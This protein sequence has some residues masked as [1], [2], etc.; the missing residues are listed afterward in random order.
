VAFH[1]A[2]DGGL[3][4]KGVCWSQDFGF[5]DLPVDFSRFCVCVA[6]AAESSLD[7][8]AWKGLWIESVR[9]PSQQAGAKKNGANR[10]PEKTRHSR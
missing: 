4:Q 10:N 7:I 9:L 8:E 6:Y 5:H 3:R 1:K 2:F